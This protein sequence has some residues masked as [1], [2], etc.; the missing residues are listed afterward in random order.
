MSS[1][2][3][4]RKAALIYKLRPPSKHVRGRVGART[5]AQGQGT[6]RNRRDPGAAKKDECLLGKR[7]R[8]RLTSLP[9]R[10]QLVER[11]S[12]AVASGARKTIASAPGVRIVVASAKFPEKA[13]RGRK[14][15]GRDVLF[16]RTQSRIA[17]DAASPV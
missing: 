17:E 9:E 16:T 14:E 1:Y 7:Q 8:R 5:A 6:R 4:E 15:S 3:S 10:Q 2:S 13:Y 12:Q 11:F